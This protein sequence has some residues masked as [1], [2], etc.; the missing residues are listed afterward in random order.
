[1]IETANRPY[2]DIFKQGDEGDLE[3]PKL[4]EKPGCTVLMTVV[5]LTLT[6]PITQSGW[7]DVFGDGPVQL[8]ELVFRQC[9]NY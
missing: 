1:M 6:R 5:A 9:C 2:H 4:K 7:A 3:S 8:W